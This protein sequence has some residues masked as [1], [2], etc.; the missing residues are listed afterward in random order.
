ME[1]HSQMLAILALIR[2]MLFVIVHMKVNII[3]LIAEVI[4]FL[5]RVFVRAIMMGVIVALGR[6]MVKKFA[7]L[8]FALLL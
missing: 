7:H 5:I 8:C 3:H 2:A 4:L 1:A 6:L